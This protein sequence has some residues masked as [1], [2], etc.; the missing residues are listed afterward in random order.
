MFKKR[1]NFNSI[2]IR[3]QNFDVIIFNYYHSI[4]IIIKN[5]YTVTL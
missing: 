5:Y 1:D 2:K 3:I 4:K